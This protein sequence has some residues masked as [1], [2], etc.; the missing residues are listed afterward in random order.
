MEENE[1]LEELQVRL[2]ERKDTARKIVFRI[3]DA[4]EEGKILTL[5]EVFFD[6]TDTIFVD[7][8]TEESE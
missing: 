3:D 4:S 2:N 6:G 1:W 8:I 5:N 7:F